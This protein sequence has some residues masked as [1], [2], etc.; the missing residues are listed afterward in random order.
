MA[1]ARKT[2]ARWSDS[3][4]G[5]TAYIAARADAQKRAN[6]LGM[7]HGLECNEVFRQ[8]T[9]RALPQRQNRC[10]HEL[11]C[12]VVMPESLDKCM[13]GHGPRSV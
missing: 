13:P 5:R 2:V 1:R 6:E 4:E 9:F 10:G 7:D 11:R 3:V 8:W 12:E